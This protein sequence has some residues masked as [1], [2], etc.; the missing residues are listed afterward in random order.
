MFKAS[1]E[2][3]KKDIEEGKNFDAEKDKVIMIGVQDISDVQDMTKWA[4][5]TYS[6]KY[7]KTAEGGVWS[8]SGVDGQIGSQVSKKDGLHE[9]S[10]Q[11]SLDGW[12][13]IDFNWKDHPLTDDLSKMSIDFTTSTYKV[14]DIWNN[15]EA[16]N[17][18]KAF[19]QTV[20]P[21]DVVML[22]LYQ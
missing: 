2:T 4:V 3:R 19:T 5:D 17:T 21:H 13:K 11:M 9:G 20:Q 8:H 7:A 22:K 15:K 16:G 14:F 10:T 12:G 1:A 18:K 6:E